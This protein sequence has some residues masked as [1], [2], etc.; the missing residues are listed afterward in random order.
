MTT[1]D[2]IIAVAFSQVGVT[3]TVGSKHTDRVLQYFAE[4]GH[5]W[6]T[7]DETPWC[8]AFANW[9]CKKAMVEDTGKLNA[10]SFLDIGQPVD[11]SQAEPGDVVIL[12]RGSK[13]S[14]QGHVAFFV[15]QDSTK[16]CLIGGNQ[17]NSVCLGMYGKDRILG[18]R[19]LRSKFAS[20]D[21]QDA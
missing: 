9:A 14:A 20:T 4:I 12:W 15:D 19:R 2:R 10:R 1:N 8:A 21:A 13:T 18:I 6:V 5:K 17:D 7:D 3:E 11:L 16:V